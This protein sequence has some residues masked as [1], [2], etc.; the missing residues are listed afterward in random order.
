MEQIKADCMKQGGFKYVPFVLPREERPDLSGYDSMK[1]YR[2][3]Y[4]FGVFSR[5]VY[6]KDRLAGGFDVEVE[7]PN[8]AIMMKLNPSQLAAYRKVESGCFRQ[9]AKEVLGKEASSLT[10]ASEQLNAASARLEAAEIDGDSELV[11]LAAGFADCLTVKGYQVSSTRP[12]D[13]ARRGHD[14]ILKESDKLG[15]KE[16]DNPKPGVHY[17]P[18]LSPAQARP[19]LEREIK[20]AL[21]DL[22]CGKEFYSRYAPRQAA[23]DARVMNEY[24]PLMG[25]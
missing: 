11:R 13:L 5:H 15:A 25:L 12:T 17:A 7:D 4:G 24:G 8:N 19:Y 23:I 9:A 20:A 14:E 22:E 3:K 16:F 18:N 2:Q 1:A 21:D 6:P 10:D